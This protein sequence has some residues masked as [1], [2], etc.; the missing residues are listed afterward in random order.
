MGDPKCIH[1]EFI[2]K[3]IINYDCLTPFPLRF[4]F[5]IFSLCL[6]PYAS[7]FTALN[8]RYAL[9]AMPFAIFC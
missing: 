3:E 5:W 9:C 6:A 1:E 7:R 2:G 8:T 4:L